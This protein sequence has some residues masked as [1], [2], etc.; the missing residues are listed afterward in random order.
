MLFDNPGNH[1]L[2]H[3][4]WRRQNDLNA[5]A[6]DR[7]AAQGVE[8]FLGFSG[9]DNGDSTVSIRTKILYQPKPAAQICDVGNSGSQVSICDFH[10]RQ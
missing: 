9:D 1:S 5:E 2:I 6:I 4:P 10:E 7:D 3:E 8:A